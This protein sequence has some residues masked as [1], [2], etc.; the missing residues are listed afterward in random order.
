MICSSLN[1]LF[2]MSAIL[3]MC[4]LHFLYLGTAG[5]GQ[6]RQA[7][8]NFNRTTI[9]CIVRGAVLAVQLNSPIAV[10]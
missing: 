10:G 6:V 7:T 9:V 3:L 2:L 5:G 1:L 4:G 8:L